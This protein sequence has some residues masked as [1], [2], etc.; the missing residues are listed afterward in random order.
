MN[1]DGVL[2]GGHRFKVEE[3]VFFTRFLRI[4]RIQEKELGIREQS[5]V[6][7][8]SYLQHVFKDKDKGKEMF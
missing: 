3:K 1:I 5:K 2:Q 6:V 8:T 7:S 4:T